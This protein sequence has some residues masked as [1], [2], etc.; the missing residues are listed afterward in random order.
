MDRHI[1]ASGGDT[2]RK[3]RSAVVVGTLAMCGTVVSLQQTLVLPMLPDFPRLLN[4]TIDN[5]S[6]L[7]TATLLAGAVATP[8]LSRLADMFG[9]KRMMLVA[10]AIMA[11]GSLLGAFSQALPLIIAGRALQGVGVALIPIGI[12]IMRDE[13]PRERLPLGVSLMSGTLAIGAGVGLPLAGLIIE[14]LDWH[15]VFLVSAFAGVA[16]FVAVALAVPE[17]P[18]RTRGSFDYRGAVLLSL[19]VT[20]LL[21]ALSK[22]AHWGWLSF[23]TVGS[24]LL[25]LI[26]V[27]VWLPFELRVASPLVDV[28]VAARP[29]VLLVNIASVLTG[30]A[31]FANMLGSTQLLQQPTKT[32]YGLGFDVLHTG[33][34]MAPSVLVF[35]AM[36]PVSA[37]I[38]RRFGPQTTL[39]A[40]AL[41]MAAAYAGRVFLSGNLWQIVAGSMLVGV[42]TSMTFAAM[43]SLIMRAVPATETASANG[44][45][46]LLRSV[47]TSTSSA[48]LAAVTTTA[49]IHVDGTVFPSFGAF[50]TVFWI[51]A[52]SSLAAGL[53][54]IPLF[55]M[56][57]QGTE[58]PATV[59]HGQEAVVRGRVVNSG[60]NAIRNA[61][62]TLLTPSG[63]QVDWSQADSSG[64]FSLAIPG[65]DRYLIVTAAEGWAPYSQLAALH[66]GHDIEPIVLRK[67]LTLAGE[68]SDAQGPIAGATVA[69]TRLS[70]E[71]VRAGQ[72]SMDGRYEMPLPS[73]G[74]YVLTVVTPSALT[75]ARAVT[76]WGAERVVDIRLP[77]GR[78]NG[79]AVACAPRR[80]RLGAVG[81]EGAQ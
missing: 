63:Q 7:I 65:P 10:L 32:G 11:A 21:L 19:A 60:G 70:G 31:M 42:G 73:S 67:R 53:L 1:P 14:H 16:M 15:S 23:Q 50:T 47:G 72:T 9:K 66:A 38:T 69:L 6:W 25:G 30:F 5:A 49:V 64:A 43:P 37:S 77:A 75:A 57:E 33:L 18:V 24:A 52:A 79:S 36:A 61:V 29:A 68:V 3:T 35:G 26:L 12:A 54:A 17:S 56:P 13:L 80:E 41:T 55:R 62:V 39:L 76:I 81:Q 58:Q 74:R 45:N 78:E 28:R 71:A 22:G 8:T 20:A 51:A 40:G 59:E 2:V 4:T 34:W 44:L 27:I 46:T 48:A